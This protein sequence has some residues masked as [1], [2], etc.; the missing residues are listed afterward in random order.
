MNEHAITVGVDGSQPSYTA[1][2]WAAAEAVRREMP[3]RIVLAYDWPYVGDLPLP[4]LL[5]VE[6]ARA[7]GVE[8]DQPGLDLGHA[9]HRPRRATRSDPSHHARRGS[10]ARRHRHW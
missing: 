7:A 3:L 4:P 2:R 10:R 5:D 8:R 9:R 1:L 6:R